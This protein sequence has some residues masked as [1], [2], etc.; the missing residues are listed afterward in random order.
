MSSVRITRH[1]LGTAVTTVLAVTLG[2]GLLTVPAT[3]AS[4]APGAFAAAT[5]EAATPIADP[6]GTLLGAGRTGFLTRNYIGPDRYKLRWTTY[7]DGTTTTLPATDLTRSEVFS[8]ETSDILMTSEEGL[9]SGRSQHI[10]LRNMTTGAAPVDVDFTKLGADHGFVGLVGSTLLATGTGTDGA[11]EL[12]LLDATGDTRSARKVTGLPEGAIIHSV[13][14]SHGGTALLGYATRSDT[15]IDRYRTTVD[16]ATAE[17]GPAF[18]VLEGNSTGSTSA[19]S[20]QYAAWPETYGRNVTLAIADRT[21]ETVRRV[22]VGKEFGKTH[23][24]LVG[25]W[26]TY[27]TPVALDQGLDSPPV[28][29]IQALTARSTTSD[30]TVKLLDHI[31]TAVPAPDG[32]LLVSGGL[33]GKGEGLYR[34]APGEDGRPA[35]E[36]VA[37]SGQP[38]ELTYLGTDLHTVD[39]DGEPA[40]THL[41]WR[42][43]RVNADV[44]LKLTHRRSG[45]TFSTK[46]HVTFRPPADYSYGSQTFGLSW[47]EIA[48][49]SNLGR[50]ASYGTYDWSFRAVPQNGI[51]PDLVASGQFHANHTGD[52]HDLDDDRAPD[53]LARDAEGVLWWTDTAYDA[54]G[55]TLT[56]AG[57]RKRAGYSWHV[58]DRIESVG[59]LGGVG[60]D[61]VARDRSGVLWRY[62]GAGPS[63]NVAF[64]PRTRIGG[65]W[66][67]YTELTGG[68]DLNSDGKPD[69]V[70]VDKAG[71]LW[72]YPSSASRSA[73]YN[74][75]KK[76]GHG[77]GIYNQITATGDIGGGIRGGRTAGDLV[78]RDKAGKLW[79]YLGKGDGTFAARTPIG[80]GW[81]PYTDI[82]GIGDGN[83]DGKP[84][85]YARGAGNTSYFYA[86]TGDW[87][88]PFAARKA[89]PVL[90]DDESTAY[91]Q[92]F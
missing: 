3:A 31:N 63:F 69:L 71:D 9:Y 25:T 78:A 18:A 66:N 47:A 58:Y 36:L 59:N 22:A 4:A 74:P 39:L 87:K 2:A 91:N 50:N 77:W 13:E 5:A 10:T 80:A 48:E 57:E 32:T 76:I 85:L 55:K 82:V 28:G 11:G 56:A 34:I 30:E 43:S 51:G 86:G 23:V 72:L 42:M 12:L 38:T 19:L 83:K 35:A 81:G 41:K 40:W 68:S 89:S 21:T 64:P 61:F 88:Y 62:D 90:G 45:E 6:G 54:A 27:G 16:V 53:L 24:G 14:A 17:A 84:D 8:T 70:A 29:M 33:V 1:G 15:V 79:L 65:G 37:S 60:G 46:M 75:R 67:T 73:L 26:V 7:A 44:Y 52:A 20:P 92:V 49:K